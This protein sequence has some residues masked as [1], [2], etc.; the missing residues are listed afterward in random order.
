MD[1]YTLI[2]KL[3]ASVGGS[4]RY[5][6]KVTLDFSLGILSWLE[7]E[8]KDTKTTK[9]NTDEV[10]NELRQIG[11]LDW[12]PNY[13]LAEIIDGTQWKVIVYLDDYYYES[14]GSNAYP[15]TWKA[16]CSIIRKITNRPFQ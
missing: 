5:N 12:Y 4:G 10:L 9:F 2:T 15:V 13:D 8:S 1:E 14:V 7:K 11:I 3:R 16:F 6:Y